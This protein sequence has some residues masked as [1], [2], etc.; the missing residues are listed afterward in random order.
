MDDNSL[1]ALLIAKR[2]TFRTTTTVYCHQR[3]ITSRTI[4]G[5]G[6]PPPAAAQDGQ[7][8]DGPTEQDGPVEQGESTS[9]GPTISVG[10]IPLGPTLNTRSVTARQLQI[11]NLPDHRTSAKAREPPTDKGGRGTTN[12]PHKH[13]L[14]SLAFKSRNYTNVHLRFMVRV[15]WAYICSS[16]FVLFWP[17]HLNTARTFVLS[18][19]AFK[20]RNYTNV[21]LLWPFPCEGERSH[22]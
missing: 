15:G 18:F 2:E 5:Y 22:I 21:P 17:A 8:D 12:H 20:S 11:D 9:F 16:I 1:D 10:Q 13:S 7:P 14:P 19:L 6:P 3:W 4:M